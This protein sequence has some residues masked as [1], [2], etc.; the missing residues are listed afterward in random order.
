MVVCLSELLNENVHCLRSFF[1]CVSF[2]LFRISTF[3]W[4]VGFIGESVVFCLNDWKT[5]IFLCIKWTGIVLTF[6]PRCAG[7]S[8][9]TNF[10][11]GGGGVGVRG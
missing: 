5:N 9:G 3:G 4:A 6:A 2:H 1:H 7:F 8:I 10:L 11:G